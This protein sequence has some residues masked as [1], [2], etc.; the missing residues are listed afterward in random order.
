MQFSEWLKEEYN[1]AYINLVG[2]DNKVNY[3]KCYVMNHVYDWVVIHEDYRV[4]FVIEVFEHLKN[5][6]NMTGLS[7]D[8]I[9]MNLSRL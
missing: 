3:A 9:F 2:E 8:H 4:E 6:Y 1:E 7:D 5:L